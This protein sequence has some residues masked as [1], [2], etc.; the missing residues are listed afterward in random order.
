[1]QD[2]SLLRDLLI[3]VAFAIPI[4]A[5][6]ERL[7][8]PS[9]VAFLVAGMAIGPY[10][11]ALISRPDGVA[12]LAELGVVLLLFEIGLEVSLAHVARMGRLVFMGG[13]LQVGGTVALTIAVGWAAGVPLNRAAAFGCLLALSS[14]AIVLKSYRDRGELDAP[15]GRAAFGVLLFQDLAVVPLMVLV[16]LLAGSASGGMAEGLTR[17]ALSIAVVGAVVLVGR[18]VVPWV[19]HRVANL[20]D[21]DL[22]TLAIGF[23][24]LGAAFL[25]ASVGLSLALGAFLAGLVISESEYGAQALSD[26]LPFRALF[27]GIFFT[28][29][30]MLLDLGFVAEHP[31]LVGGVASGVILGKALIVA[32]VVIFGLRRALGT[33]VLAG[34]GLAQVGEFSF[35]LAGVALAAGLVTDSAYQVFLAATVLSMLVAPLLIDRAYWVADVVARVAGG[36]VSERPAIDGADRRSLRDHA[37]I[38]GYGMSGRHLAKVLKAAHLPYVVLEVNGRVVRAGRRQGEPIHF[39]DGTRREVLQSAGI[40]EAQVVIFNI[41]SPVDERRAVTMARSLNPSV[42][43]IVRTRTVAAIQDLVARGATEVVVEEYEAALELFQRV[44]RHYRIPVNTI[45]AE[46][47]A[48]RAEHYGILR[49]IPKE[50]L[51]LDDLR[52][53]G[54]HHA[55]D[56][57]E[58]EEGSRAVGENPVTLNLRNT[59]GATVVAV[60]R[61][62]VAYYAPDPSF[63]FQP[64]DTVVIVGTAPALERGSEPFRARA[65]SAQASGS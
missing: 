1:M 18:I 61:Q 46:L 36:A 16:P 59:T 63:R 25:T 42:K 57:V 27:S 31:G 39:G 64:G 15:H 20:R 49:G 65:K 29:V 9:I 19:L 34:L 52:Y 21:R 22:F 5:L 50:A 13:T 11:L 4:V 60:V 8:V 41:S 2:L 44:L 58:V 53:L 3:L 47:D 7:R 38:V 26:V 51:H 43:I 54:V 14:T 33:G 6:A 10:G 17:I 48:L 62:G 12:Q 55:L 24:G 56:L 40:R 28:S 32:L 37:I 45:S 23:F 35:V 30:G